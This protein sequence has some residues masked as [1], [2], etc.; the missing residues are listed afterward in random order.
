MRGGEGERMR[1]NA[2]SATPHCHAY[3]Y[4]RVEWCTERQLLVPLAM[5]V[6]LTSLPEPMQ[7]PQHRWRGVASPN[8]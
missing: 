2:C 4:L 8:P 7:L 5:M 6:L 1:R 3:D